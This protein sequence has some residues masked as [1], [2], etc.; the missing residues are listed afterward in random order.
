MRCS[1][2]TRAL[3]TPT[4]D[5]DWALVAGH[6]AACDRCA[7]FAE[8]AARLD[9]AFAATRPAPPAPGQWDA[10]WAG[11][12]GGLELE[13]GRDHAEILPM[14]PAGLGGRGS[15]RTAWRRAGLVLAFGLAQAAAV[16]VAFRLPDPLP[17]AG[18]SDLAFAP[19]AA[20]AVAAA[21]PADP[22]EP[23]ADD[24]IV[25]EPGQFVAI[26][27]SEEGLA[28]VELAQRDGL[29]QVGGDFDLLGWAEAHATN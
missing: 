27:G 12:M 4:A 17:P 10:L 7:A 8:Q 5:L 6:L 16:L 3:S 21:E 2:V 23:V 29:D 14:A 28:V 24:M 11:V 9:R 13:S 22:A 15:S 20:V 25:I 18:D 26:R 1:E 19:P